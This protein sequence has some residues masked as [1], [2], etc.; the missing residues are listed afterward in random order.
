MACQLRAN[1]GVDAMQLQRLAERL[2]LR[3][4]VQ[5]GH[6]LDHRAL[7]RQAARRAHATELLARPVGQRHE[8]GIGR[9]RGGQKI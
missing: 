3:M 7:A 1:V 4:G 9:E 8:I 6:A 5:H 2:A